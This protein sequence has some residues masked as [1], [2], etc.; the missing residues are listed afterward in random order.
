MNTPDTTQPLTIV[1]CGGH[2]RVVL[3]AARAAG[4]TIAGL[5]DIRWSSRPETILGCPV[6]GGPE[7]LENSPPLMC[8]LGL[9]D[10]V[11]RIIWLQKLKD[12]GHSLP[13]IV[14]PA[15]W[16]SPAAHLGEGVVVNAGAVVCAQAVVGAASILNTGASLDHES[17]LGA[18]C[19]LAP[20]A[21]VAGRSHLGTLC[22]AGMGSV[23]I[24][25]IT[26]GDSV[27]I[28]AGA[29]VIRDA[30]GGRTLI[31][32]PAKERP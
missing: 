24:D 27:V 2:A 18:G 5:V 14:H 32:V 7:V 11:Q 20:G 19:H 9:G 6:L 22:F 28:G 23:V 25:G 10:N 13:A 17:T 12:M 31:G 21:R 3:D 16:V 8:A 26:L 29:V 15:A 4:W 1:G 30:D